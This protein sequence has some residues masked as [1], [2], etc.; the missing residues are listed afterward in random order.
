MKRAYSLILLCAVGVSANAY[1]FNFVNNVTGNYI[2]G[3]AWATL[4]VVDGANAGDVDF[5][6]THLATSPAQKI[7]EI[8]LSMVTYTAV[9]MSNFSPAA[10]FQSMSQ[11]ND[12]ITD[13]GYKFDV[14]IAFD[15]ANPKKIAPGDSVSF[16][17]SGAGISAASFSALATGSTD[18]YAMAHFNGLPDGSSSKIS[19][20]PEPASMAALGLGLAAFAKKRRK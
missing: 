6:L 1:T 9:T 15:P 11:G 12:A 4:D 17:L 20:V 10:K 14:S 16:T 5:T 8:E 13:A 7:S 2:P 19:A 18:I 3:S